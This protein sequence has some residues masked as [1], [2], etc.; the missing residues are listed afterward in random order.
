MD[1]RCGEGLEE[2]ALPDRRLMV[3]LTEA[4]GCVTGKCVHR[5]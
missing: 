5:E 1:L 2:I 3:A 4:S